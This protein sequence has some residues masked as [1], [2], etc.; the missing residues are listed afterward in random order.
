MLQWEF[1][2]EKKK[3]MSLDMKLTERPC[4]VHKGLDF[5]LQDVSILSFPLDEDQ[6]ET[7]S[8]DCFSVEILSIKS[9]CI[10][11]RSVPFIN[12]RLALECL[13]LCAKQINYVPH[14]EGVQKLVT[15]DES[16][17]CKE[18][19]ATWRRKIP[20]VLQMKK[21]LRNGWLMQLQADMSN[22]RHKGI[23]DCVAGLCDV[24]YW[25]ICR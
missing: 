6:R 15:K 8:K 2:A 9:L 13:W 22:R 18:P 7:Y 12:Q 19:H 10:F 1:G 25:I 16:H 11:L 5:S 21:G 4:L 14:W 17:S 24:L 23:F 3:C 20:I